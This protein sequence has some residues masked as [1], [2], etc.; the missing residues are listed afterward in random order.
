M[1]P[2]IRCVAKLLCGDYKYVSD[3]HR[4]MI[5]DSVPWAVKALKHA[6]VDKEIADTVCIE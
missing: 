3:A 2:S 6:H 4:Q 1:N 5:V